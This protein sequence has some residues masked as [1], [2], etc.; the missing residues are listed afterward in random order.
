MSKA[1]RPSRLVS[2]VITSL[3]LSIQSF[4]YLFLQIDQ[5]PPP[6]RPQFTTPSIQSVN[7]H[8]PTPATFLVP[9]RSRPLVTVPPYNYLI[10][11]LSTCLTALIPCFHD[12]F[13]ASCVYF[14][15]PLPSQP[16]VL[17]FTHPG[18][19]PARL[20][21]DHRR[22]HTHLFLLSSDPPRFALAPVRS[23]YLRALPSDPKQ[24]AA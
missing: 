5:Y 23:R 22:H 7:L 2:E 9:L 15:P 11:L 14:Y 1:A 13:S 24:S 10:Y 16:S 4:P 17:M 8:T 12:R 21:S 3:S 18:L 6:L 20:S 19:V